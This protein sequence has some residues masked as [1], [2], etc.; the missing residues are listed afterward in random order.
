M[1]QETLAQRLYER[2]C[3]SVGGKAF[4]GDPLPSW[5]EFRN[6]P[7]KTKQATAWL[8]VASEAMLCLEWGK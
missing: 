7:S 6:D 1:D 3:L 8:D 4:N 2:Y 5:Q